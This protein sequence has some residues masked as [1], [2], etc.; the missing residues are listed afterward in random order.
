MSIDALMGE[1]RPEVLHENVF[2][3]QRK[4]KMTAIRVILTTWDIK[5]NSEKLMMETS[6]CFLHIEGSRRRPWRKKPNQ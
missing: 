6:T 3:F 4:L 2:F 5:M 1:T